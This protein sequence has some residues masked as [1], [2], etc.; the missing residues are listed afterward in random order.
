MD[1]SL[2]AGLPGHLSPSVTKYPGGLCITVATE[3]VR[4]EEHHVD[5]VNVAGVKTRPVK[6]TP[7]QIANSAGTDPRIR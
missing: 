1:G 3:V 4:V 5:V 2:V 7:D 6:L